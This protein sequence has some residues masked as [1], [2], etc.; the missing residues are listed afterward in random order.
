VRKEG[1]F[2]VLAEY[3][4]SRV[5]VVSCKSLFSAHARSTESASLRVVL[6]QIEYRRLEQNN[7]RTVDYSIGLLQRIYRG[8]SGKRRFRRLQFRVDE[9][10]AQR[11]LHEERRGALGEVRE[12]R[13]VMVTKIVCAVKAWLWRRLVKKMRAA[14]TVIQCSFRIFRACNL[15][16]A[17][18]RRRDMGPEVR[19]TFVLLHCSSSSFSC[20]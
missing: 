7:I 11:R 12:Y 14:C 18:R 17:E 4:S 6:P 10:E 15:V 16:A 3:L 1:P 2:N 19:I 13:R 5:R 8:F 9:K 20:L